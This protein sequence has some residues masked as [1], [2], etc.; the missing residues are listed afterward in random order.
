M[1]DVITF[2]N[3]WMNNVIGSGLI[4]ITASATSYTKFSVPITKV[5]AG[6]P[7][8]CFISFAIGSS[9]SKPAVGS[10]FIIDDLSFGAAT[11]VEEHGNNQPFVFS[12]NQNYPNPFNPSTII[13]YQVANEEH[14]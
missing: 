12:L 10:Y 7:D 5:G 4:N 8:S 1:I 6:T 9:N 11:G 2:K 14:G 3:G 13:N